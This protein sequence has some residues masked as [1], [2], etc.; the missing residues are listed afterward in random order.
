MSDNRVQ[1]WCVY[2][3]FV[4]IA[5]FLIGWVGLAGFVPPPSPNDTAAHIAQ[6]YRD[7]LIPIRVGLVLSLVASAL[8]LPWGGAICAQMMR[9]EG[10]RAPLTWAW[11]AAQ[12]CVVIEFVYPCT[13]WL[14]AAFRIED[15]TRV[16]TFNDLGWLPFLGIVCTGMF[17][18]VALAVL[19]I[20]DRRPDPVFPRW[21]AYFQLWCA[22]GVSLTFGVYIFKSGPMAWNG[23]LGFWIPVTF[24]FIW[25]VVTTLVTARAIKRDHADGDHDNIVV[26]VQALESQIGLLQAASAEVLAT[27]QSSRSASD[28]S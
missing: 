8:L 14:V 11:I 26:R 6:L 3:A 2:S 15:E 20:R 4:F 19:T 13:F 10:S 24:Y 16:Q 1:L 18:M 12:G 25:V 7:R 5:V 17:Q 9:I 27:G 28:N 23:A 21:F 22:L